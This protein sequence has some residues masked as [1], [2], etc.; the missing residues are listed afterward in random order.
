MALVVVP[1][2]VRLVGSAVI[3]A[4][5]AGVGKQKSSAREKPAEMPA[6]SS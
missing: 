5:G 1:L 6:S 3:G 4:D 2:L